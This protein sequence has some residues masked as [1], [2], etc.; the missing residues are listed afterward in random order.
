[1]LFESPRLRLRK[2]TKEDTELYNK[3]RNDLD[4]MYNTNP[5]LDVYTLESTEDFV[6][7]VILGSS[8]AK[9]YIITETETETPIGIRIINSYRL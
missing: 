7:Q 3:W 4:V 8:T 9:S 2:M 6:E 1:M 5:S